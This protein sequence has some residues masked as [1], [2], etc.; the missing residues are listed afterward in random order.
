MPEASRPIDRRRFLLGASAGLGSLAL[1]G[2]TSAPAEAAPPSATERRYDH[3]D[4]VPLGYWRWKDGTAGRRVERRTFAST[5]VLH[6]RLV[7]F[8]KDLRDQS[9]RYGGLVSMNLIVTAGTFVAKPGQHGLGAAFDLDQVRWANGAITPYRREHASPDLRT[10]RRYLA[11]DAIARRHFHW[12]LDGGFNADHGDHLHLDL[13]GGRL[14]CDTTALS[15]TAFVQQV[16]NAFQGSRLPVDRVWGPATQRAFAESCR[17]LAISGDPTRNVDAYRMWL[18][19]VAA[20]GFAD[21][22]FSAAPAVSDDPLAGL[23]DPILS[24]V[25]KV[26]EDLVAA[27]HH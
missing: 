18:L 22:P 8:V 17:R 20:C 2:L 4:G 6:D 9:A 5:A 13:A 12:V 10:R 21:Q 15:D 16:C 24:G 23:I 26:A 1:L 11:L 3:L 7:R 25:Q 19:R 14:V 27:L